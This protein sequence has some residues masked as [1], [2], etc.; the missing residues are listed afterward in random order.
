M[1]A[2]IPV[3]QQFQIITLEDM[4]VVKLM[5]RIDTKYLMTKKQLYQLLS[6]LKNDYFVQSINNEFLAPYR[7]LYFD[8]PNVDMYLV[9]HNR[10]LN[11]QKLRTRCYLNSGLM[12]CE[13]KNKLNTGRTQKLRIP[14]NENIFENI[15]ADKQVE[16]FVIE[17]LKYDSFQMIPQ[18][19]NNFQRITLVNNDKTERITIDGDIK[20]MNHV[21]EKSDSIS[22][23]VILELKQNGFGYSKIKET[24]LDMRI[25]PKKIS[26][27][28]LGTVL[29]NP[30]VKNNRF[31][32]KIRYINNL[33][34]NNN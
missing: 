8:T 34:N 23:L 10:K 5:N 27:Y 28:C 9:H 4:N 6:R 3:L 29:T 15:H 20:F 14:I 24:L 16:D 12:F 31:K 30:N 1:T 22:D 13:I 19:E 11:R 21:T 32:I 26:K 2:N 17:N 7:T 33:I 18:L 25:K